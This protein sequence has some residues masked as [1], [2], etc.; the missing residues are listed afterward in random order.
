MLPGKRPAWRAKPLWEGCS[1]IL[2]SWQGEGLKH[3][4]H[5]ISSFQDEWK[6]W[7][8]SSFRSLIPYRKLWRTL[9]ELTFPRQSNLPS[10]CHSLPLGIFITS[11]NQATLRFYMSHIYSVSLGGLCTSVQLHQYQIYNFILKNSFNFLNT[12]FLVQC[13]QSYTT[14]HNHSHYGPVGEQSHLCCDKTSTLGM[15][16]SPVLALTAE[17]E[18]WECTVFPTSGLSFCLCRREVEVA[19]GW[20]EGI[21][22]EANSRLSLVS[23]PRKCSL[24]CP[25]G[26][27]V[28]LK[29]QMLHKENRI[30]NCMVKHIWKKCICQKL[31]KLIYNKNPQNL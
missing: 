3:I 31:D 26:I 14:N 10:W 17:Q 16:I 11:S 24:T 29:I 23:L 9:L 15:E 5:K 2:G 12:K 6:Q 7:T 1:L 19:F 4:H 13:S 8:I 21:Q 25:M 30:L 27:L 18:L 20:L 28:A 22:G